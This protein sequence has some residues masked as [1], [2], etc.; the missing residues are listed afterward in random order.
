MKEF[1]FNAELWERIIIAKQL[2]YSSKVIN[3]MMKC[4]TIIQ[5]E[6]IMHDA[7]LGIGKYKD[8]W[9]GG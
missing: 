4:T 6:N 9:E 8:E 7:R 1:D 5:V 3:D 2:E